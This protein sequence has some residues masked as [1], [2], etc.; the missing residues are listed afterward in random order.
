MILAI[1]ELIQLL[2][3]SVDINVPDETGAIVTD[4]YY[5]EMSDEDILLF[6]KLGIN[7]IYPNI[8][9]LDD[10]PSNCSEYAVILLAKIELYLKL[11]VI[12]ADKVDLGAGDASISNSQRFDHY[13]KLVEEA[14]AEYEN[15]LD[16]EGQGTVTTYDMLNSKYSHTRRYYEK[17]DIPVVSIKTANIS[18][19]GFDF[20]WGVTSIP[21][22]GR[23]L[24]YL[25]KSP[26]YNKYADGSKVEDHI[27]KDASLKLIRET[28]D[29]RNMAKHISGLE[30][31]TTYYVLVV[32]QCRNSVWGCK[33][34][35]VT[36]LAEFVEGD[37]IDE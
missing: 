11:A 31:D 12:R 1:E 26:I 36:T 23:Y 17:Q 35:S 20:S 27:L 13:M 21:H 16:N 18:S 9:D 37:E 6:I 24:V 14:R 7:R 8:T 30:P 5:V 15:W 22:F 10:L 19:D 3:N 29:F 25:S 32:A 28:Y 33:E 34:I 2:R 4:P